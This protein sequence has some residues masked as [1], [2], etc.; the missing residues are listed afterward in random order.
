MNRIEK[1]RRMIAS[2]FIAHHNKLA[3][4]LMENMFSGRNRLQGSI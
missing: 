2:I 3:C 4:T 1:K